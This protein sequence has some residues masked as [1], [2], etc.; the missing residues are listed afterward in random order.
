MSLPGGPGSA[1]PGESWRYLRALRHAPPGLAAVRGPRKRTFDAAL[2]Q[3]EQL[4]AAAD[5]VGTAVRPLPLFYGLSQ[6]G[7]ALAA[8]W[9]RADNGQLSG[10]GITSSNFRDAKQLAEVTVRSDGCGSF[11][12]IAELLGAPNLSRPMKLGDLCGLLPN[13]ASFPLRA[14]AATPVPFRTHRVSHPPLSSGVQLMGAVT[15]PRRLWDAFP[16]NEDFDETLQLRLQHQQEMRYQQHLQRTLRRR[17]EAFIAGYPALREGWFPHGADQRIA[18]AP[19]P[20]ES[21]VHLVYPC[22]PDWSDIPD[23]ARGIHTYLGTSYAFPELPGDVVPPH[24]LVA[25]WAV[26]YALSMLARYEP[27]RWTQHTSVASSAAAVPIENL[28]TSAMTAVPQTLL[29]TFTQL[30]DQN[31]PDPSRQAVDR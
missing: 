31:A 11:T 16:V 8:A 2:E 14:E 22:P 13:L 20:I 9:V 23:S 5:V 19:A 7:R 27:D 24:P 6:A 1:S 15:L 12:T 10:H 21:G 30:Q 18:P 17:V 25:W 28:L 29:E 3:A 4:F 26:L